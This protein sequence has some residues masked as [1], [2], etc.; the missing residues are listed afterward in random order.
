MYP[1]IVDTTNMAPNALEAM[2]AP[3]V[4]VGK[5]YADKK[6]GRRMRMRR[7]RRAMRFNRNHR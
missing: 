3:P 2:N 6:I 7:I 5:E 4:F 1:D